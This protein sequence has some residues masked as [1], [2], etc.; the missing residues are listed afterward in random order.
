M[1]DYSPEDRFERRR[2]VQNLKLPCI[3]MM[4]TNAHGNSFGS[5]SFIWRT[6][7]EV[8]Q[9]QVSQVVLRVSREMP[10]FA[11]RDVRRSF[12]HKYNR[13]SGTP[14]SVLRHIYASLTG[15]QSKAP[16]GQ[17]VNMNILYCA[18]IILCVF[19][20]HVCVCV[21]VC[22]CRCRDTGLYLDLYHLSELLIVYMLYFIS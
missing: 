3:A 22:T 19:Y 9:N 5:L 4:Y 21:C 18:Y 11:S 7:D 15:D 8:D 13:L 12:V 20:V 6:G 14:K 1:Q 16:S 2:W 17:Y 10:T